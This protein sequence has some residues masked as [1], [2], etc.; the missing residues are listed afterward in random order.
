MLAG[1]D[2]SHKFRVRETAEPMLCIKEQNVMAEQERGQK[3][4]KK[5]SSCHNSCPDPDVKTLKPD[6]PSVV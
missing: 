4:K 2:S 5:K 1:W 3:K 6:I